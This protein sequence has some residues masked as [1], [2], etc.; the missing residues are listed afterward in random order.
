[1][2]GEM[3]RPDARREEGMTAEG[4]SEA[5]VSFGGGPPRPAPGSIVDPAPAISAPAPANPPIPLSPASTAELRDAVLDAASH[6]APLRVLGRATWADAGRPVHARHALSTVALR[7]IVDYVPGDLTLTARAGTP[8]AELQAAARAEGQWLPLE[9]WGGDDGSLGATLATATAGPFAAALGLPRD[10]V[11]GL[12]AVTGTGDVVRGGGRVVKNV[13]GFDLVRLLTG[14][15]GTLGV[16]TEATVR[17]RAVPE[18][19]ETLAVAAPAADLTGWLD[20]LRRLP[21]APLATELLND[22]M[23]RTLALPPAT[24]LLVRLG[25]NADAV[26]AQRSALAGLGDAAAV[27]AEIWARL[28]GADAGGA[29]VFRLSAPPADAAHLWTHAHLLRDA[30]GDGVRV[31]ASI[32]RGVVRVT[33]PPA[34]DELL[35][36]ALGGGARDDVRRIFE[37]LPA[38]LWPRLAPGPADDRLSRRVRDAFDPYRLLNPGIFGEAPMEGAT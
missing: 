12:E 1:M 38:P 34:P 15:W 23:A 32:A 9:P 14:A 30:L 26:A 33:L 7:G 19:D 18:A 3:R 27:D 21:V 22:A 31:H 17:L 28:R 10:T 25:G 36:D 20:R 35:S 6:R 29:V 16:L 4:A 37:R 24:Q 13:A 11:L 2:S 8:L 5:I